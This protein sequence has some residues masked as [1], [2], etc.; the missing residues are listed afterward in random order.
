MSSDNPDSEEAAVS[1]RTGELHTNRINE[2]KSR[3]NLP[4]DIRTGPIAVL[5]AIPTEVETSN[6]AELQSTLPDPPIFGQSEGD[7]ETSS[8]TS[9]GKVETGQVAETELKPSSYTYISDEGWFEAV[10]TDPFLPGLVLEDLAEEFVLTLK[11][12]LE[13]LLQLGA[14]L[15]VYVYLSLLD[16]EGFRMQGGHYQYAVDRLPAECTSGPA[17]VSQFDGDSTKAVQTLMAEIRE[18]SAIPPE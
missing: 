5:H 10:T 12:G 18:Q 14:E 2:L 9:D 1:T 17:K 15:P 6:Y 11:G 4:A 7:P 8:T 13:C 3:T 16:V